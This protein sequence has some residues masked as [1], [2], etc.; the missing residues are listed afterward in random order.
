LNEHETPQLEIG[1]KMEW[2]YHNLPKV[3]F[4]RII[5]RQKRPVL[6]RIGTPGHVGDSEEKIVRR[7]H[8]YESM[9][10]SQRARMRTFLC[11]LHEQNRGKRAHSSIHYVVALNALD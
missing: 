3:N 11:D 4:S 7:T 2:R 6:I 9:M 8:A 5:C 1:A 10:K